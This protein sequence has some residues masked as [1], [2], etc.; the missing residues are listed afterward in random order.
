[1]QAHPPLSDIARWLSEE[2]RQPLQEFEAGKR[3]LVQEIEE[4]LSCSTE[5][6][7]ALFDEL[8]RE[9]FVRYAAEARSIG[10]TPGYWVI[11]PSPAANPDEGLEDDLAVPTE[12]PG[13]PGQA[14]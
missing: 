2:F 7:D 1:M 8:E 9:G 5:E 6:A 11:Y 14:R 12:S 10:G 13:Q 4:R 3:G